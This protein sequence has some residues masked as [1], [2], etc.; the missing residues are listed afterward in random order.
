MKSIAFPAI[1][2]GKLQYPPIEVAA[3][4][5]EAA[6]YFEMKI[7]HAYLKDMTIV[8]YG[9]DEHIFKVSKRVGLGFKTF[10]AVLNCA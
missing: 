5:F 7:P 8:I 3:A 2:T 10:H 1:G 9:T 6:R 4:F